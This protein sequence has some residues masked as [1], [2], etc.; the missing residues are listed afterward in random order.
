MNIQTPFLYP[1]LDESKSINLERDAQDLIAAGVKI[2]QLR[3]KKMPNADFY[4]LVTKLVPACKRS[5]VLLILND[6]VDVCMITEASGIHLGQDD[7]PAT[8]ARQLLPHA[9]IGLSTH[10]IHQVQDADQLPIDYIS[11]GPIFPTT[12]KENPDPVVGLDLLRKVRTLTSKPIV[13]V[14]GITENEI[15]ELLK[16]GAD[17]VAVISEIYRQDIAQSTQRLLKF[18]QPQRHRDEEV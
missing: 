11:I 8:E 6:R 10:N 14:G 1:I 3:C 2:L 4:K 17:G 18:F 7:F 9:I 16:A 13:C 5:G 12:S 15:P